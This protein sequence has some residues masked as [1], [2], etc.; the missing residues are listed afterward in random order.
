MRFARRSRPDKDVDGVTDGSLAGVFTGSGEGFAL[1]GAG[2]HRDFGSLSDRL[3]GQ[4]AV[5]V[6]RSLVV[7]KPVAMLL[8]AKTRP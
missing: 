4:R 8:L 1:H 3:Q 5:V 6:G 2:L 7:G